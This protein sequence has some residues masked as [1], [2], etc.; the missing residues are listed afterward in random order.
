[1]DDDQKNVRLLQEILL[2]DGELHADAQRSRKF[3]WKNLGTENILRKPLERN[4]IEFLS[5][6]ASF[7]DGDSFLKNFL[8]DSD[9]ENVLIDDNNMN[10]DEKSK[11][12]RQMRHEREMFLS[13]Q[14][15]LNK[16]M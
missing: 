7:A 12:W 13:K 9:D 14:E 3:Q 8:G 2:E 10:D 15:V 16:K 5:L 6:C 1:M 11:N 4:W